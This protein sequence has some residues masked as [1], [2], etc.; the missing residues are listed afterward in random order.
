[1]GFNNFLFSF[2]CKLFNLF[3]FVGFFFK[4]KPTQLIN[5]SHKIHLDIIKFASFFVEPFVSL[6]KKKKFCSI[7]F[8]FVFQFEQTK[9][10]VSNRPHPTTKHLHDNSPAKE[11]Q[12]TNNIPS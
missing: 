5:K 10:K 6:N 4:K 9:R 12:A 7:A 1:L 2:F 11:N 3:F 8:S